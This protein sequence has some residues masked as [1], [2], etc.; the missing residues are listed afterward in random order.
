[1]NLRLAAAQT[2]INSRIKVDDTIYRRQQ[3]DMMPKL[4]QMMEE[5]KEKLKDLAGE[6]LEYPPAASPR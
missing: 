3:F 4:I 5:E 2:V 1:M 6:I